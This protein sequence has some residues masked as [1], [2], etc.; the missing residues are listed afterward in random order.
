LMVKEEPL[1][2]SNPLLQIP[3]ALITPH[4]AAFTDLMLNGTVSFV[5]KVIRE[6]SAG[7]LPLSLL[8]HPV[9]PRNPF[10]SAESGTVSL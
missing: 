4:I 9:N 3:Q 8:N 7:K 6:L 10:N 5:A 2:T 1:S